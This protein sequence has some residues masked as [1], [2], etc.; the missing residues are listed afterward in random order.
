MKLHARHLTHKE[1]TRA[2]ILLFV[3]FVALEACAER[4][5]LFSTRDVLTAA[6]I[7][8]SWFKEFFKIVIE[9]FAEEV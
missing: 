1:A 2:T 3:A 7:V 9:R 4:H 8:A 6:T 5:I